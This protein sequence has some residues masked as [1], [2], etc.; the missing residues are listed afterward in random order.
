MFCVS[1]VS[2]FSLTRTQKGPYHVGNNIQTKCIFLGPVNYECLWLMSGFL[3]L[4]GAGHA[5]LR[6]TSEEWCLLGLNAPQIPDVAHFCADVVSLET[7]VAFCNHYLKRN[8]HC[9]KNGPF[10]CAVCQIIFDDAFITVLDIIQDMRSN[11]YSCI[12]THQF[13]D[14]RHWS[15][16]PPFDEISAVFLILHKV[17]VGNINA[18]AGRGHVDCAPHLNSRSKRGCARNERYV[19]WRPITAA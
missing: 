7:I 10:Y 15:Q 4:L 13:Q 2:V 3:W 14:I 18:L 9:T 6:D 17:G 11:L 16:A 8:G 5:E 12:G 19:K 1:L